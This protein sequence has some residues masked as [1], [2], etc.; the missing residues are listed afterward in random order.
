[1]LRPGCGIVCMVDVRGVDALHQEN[2]AREGLAAAELSTCN[3]ED[4]LQAQGWILAVQQQ[5]F[6]NWKLCLH[7]SR[8]CILSALKEARTTL[9]RGKRRGSYGSG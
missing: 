5:L 2:T 8:F 4:V 3:D 1:M 6:P 9:T 7:T